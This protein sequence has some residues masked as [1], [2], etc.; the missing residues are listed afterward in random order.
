MVKE[1]PE[2]AAVQKIVGALQ[3]L[4]GPTQDRVLASVLALL[5]K[6]VSL[7]NDTRGRTE[8]DTNHTDNQVTTQRPKG[9]TELLGEKKPGTNSQ[10]IVLFA[11]YRDKFENKPRF[12]RGDLEG[13][14]DTARLNPPGNYDRDF[15]AAVEKGWIHENNDQS[16]IT[17]SGIEIVE[18]D[19]EGERA[20]GRKKANKNL[21]KK[22]GRSSSRGR[23]LR[24]RNVKR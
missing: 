16:Y 20:Y 10:R 18:Q 21:G 19:F 8:G 9:L 2:L 1:S 24:T 11:Y 3:S 6:T 22:A 17:T 5:G 23:S 15:N 13:Y 4:D 14:F 7:P 12:S